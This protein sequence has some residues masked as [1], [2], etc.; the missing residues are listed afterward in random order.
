M[1]YVS[2]FFMKKHTNLTPIEEAIASRRLRGHGIQISPC[3]S[4]QKWNLFLLPS[5]FYFLCLIIL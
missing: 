2:G 1:F 5:F 3:H 4:I